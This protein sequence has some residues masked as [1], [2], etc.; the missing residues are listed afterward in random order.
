VIS[1]KIEGKELKESQRVLWVDLAKT[2]A[3]IGVIIDHTKALYNNNI[4]IAY[5]SYYNV[6]LFIFLMGVTSYWSSKKQSGEKVQKRILKSCKN[7]LI[8]YIIATFVY[9]VL[10]DRKFDFVV[11][12]NRLV[13]FNASGPFYYVLLY[14]QLLLIAPFVISLM[15]ASEKFAYPFIFEVIGLLMACVISWLTTNYTNVL[16]VYGGAE[17]YL[18]EPIL[19]CSIWECYL[20]SIVLA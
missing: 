10:I 15:K 18:A 1:I 13:H 20:G 8:P 2:V 14:I 6:S 7:I 12:L 5:F 9:S 16:D 4:R 19:F 17:N 3:I 11:F